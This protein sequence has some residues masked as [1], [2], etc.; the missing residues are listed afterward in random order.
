MTEAPFVGTL[1]AGGKWM[2]NDRGA[3]RPGP[4]RHLCG[5]P[6]PRF[7]RCGILQPDPVAQRRVPGGMTVFLGM[8]MMPSWTV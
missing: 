8:T 3:P 7:R 4:K 2:D 5:S 6:V 1:R